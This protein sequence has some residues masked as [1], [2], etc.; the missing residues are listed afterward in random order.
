MTALLA[1]LALAALLA[2]TALLTPSAMI[3]GASWRTAR[4][5]TPPYGSRRPG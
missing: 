5:G 2:L 1:L 4:S 3:R